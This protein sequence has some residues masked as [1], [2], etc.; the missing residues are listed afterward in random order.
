MG[1]VPG[2]A[3]ESCVWLPSEEGKV[4]P[5]MWQPMALG[6]KWEGQGIVWVILMTDVLSQRAPV[7]LFL[8]DVSK[9]YIPSPC[10]YTAYGV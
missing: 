7:C 1:E 6:L 3:Q 8:K 5:K 2:G 10:T 9:L 4:G